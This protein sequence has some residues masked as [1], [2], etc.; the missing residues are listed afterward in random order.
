M[1]APTSP[2]SYYLRSPLGS[3]PSPHPTVFSIAVIPSSL[4]SQM[5]W[6]GPGLAIPFP[7]NLC[8]SCLP[9]LLPLP[10]HPD[11]LICTLHEAERLD[12]WYFPRRSWPSLG[13]SATLNTSSTAPVTVEADGIRAHERHRETL[14]VIMMCS[15]G[16]MAGWL[17]RAMITSWLSKLTAAPSCSCVQQWVLSGD[18]AQSLKPNHLFF[19][20][21]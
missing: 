8:S 11:C 18:R 2:T 13:C 9:H 14:E 4:S 15:P 1:L 20:S 19:S 12:G 6:S 10:S 5:R 7:A 16:W 21:E 3:P 17:A